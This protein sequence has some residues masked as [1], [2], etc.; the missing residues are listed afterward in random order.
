MKGLSGGVGESGGGNFW[1]VLE[2]A[3]SGVDHDAFGPARGGSAHQVV[4]IRAC[5]VAVVILL[6]VVTLIFVVAPPLFTCSGG[7]LMCAV[8][9]CIR[10]RWVSQR[11]TCAGRSCR[12][13]HAPMGGEVR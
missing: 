5:T 4:G 7:T 1:S 10:Q 12:A 11:H 6:I 13:A 9:A 3:G 8:L 2:E